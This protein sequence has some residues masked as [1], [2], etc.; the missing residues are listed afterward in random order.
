M[1]KDEFDPTL[2]GQAVN[3][4]SEAAEVSTSLAKRKVRRKTARRTPASQLPE[5]S[6]PIASGSK[7]L[8]YAPWGTKC[9]LCGQ[10][11]KT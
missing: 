10:V 11:H 2:E 3:T 9:K 6:P 1:E 8:A 4:E 5:V 7:C